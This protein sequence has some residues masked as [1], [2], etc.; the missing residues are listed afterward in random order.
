MSVEYSIQYTGGGGYVQ[1]GLG[2]RELRGE[3]AS[4]VKSKEALPFPQLAT[5]T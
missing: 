2:G 1:Q 4:A 5:L 3:T